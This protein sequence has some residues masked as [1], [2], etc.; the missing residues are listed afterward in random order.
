MRFWHAYFSANAPGPGANRNQNHLDT[1]M[2]Q[3]LT[4]IRLPWNTD[5]SFNPAE[6]IKEILKNN[7]LE[8]TNILKDDFEKW[9][10]NLLNHCS[11][12]NK[13]KL[14]QIFEQFKKLKWPDSSS[15]TFIVDESLEASKHDQKSQ[16]DITKQ[17]LDS[18]AATPLNPEKPF[19]QSIQKIYTIL[20]HRAPS[21][22]AMIAKT[23]EG[24][25][26]SMPTTII[27][28]KTEPTEVDIQKSDWN[29]QTL[30]NEIR[31]IVIADKGSF[32][33]NTD[34]VINGNKFMN[35]GFNGT[36]DFQG[37]ETVENINFE[38]RLQFISRTDPQVHISGTFT[39][40]K[41]NTLPETYELKPIT[42]TLPKDYFK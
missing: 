1:T 35:T 24:D 8:D 6:R 42:V 36:L 18:N 17:V 7:L 28:L 30:E 5:K 13:N 23:K 34:V 41:N 26:G 19:H 9:Q 39:N 40:T 11:E 10:T 37:K 27:G 29:V 21:L 4:L 20:F 2:K 15:D 32:D 31:G 16:K 12:D 38:C 22:L 33:I 14:T 25:F 3:I